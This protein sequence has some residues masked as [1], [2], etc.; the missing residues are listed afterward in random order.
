MGTDSSRHYHF[1]IKVAQLRTYRQWKFILKR[2][3]FSLDTLW[4]HTHTHTHTHTCVYVCVCVCMCV[5]ENVYKCVWIYF[6]LYIFIYLYHMYCPLTKT[7]SSYEATEYNTFIP[8]FINYFF[9]SYFFR[10]CRL[11]CLHRPRLLFFLSFF[12][13][14]DSCISLSTCL[15]LPC[16]HI[17]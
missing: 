9:P 6:I 2:Y 3:R 17:V 13:S 5:R 11:N 12:L 8:V 1:S 15:L 16:L 10:L 4:S 14:L 7:M